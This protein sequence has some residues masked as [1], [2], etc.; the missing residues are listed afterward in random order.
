[1]CHHRSNAVMAFLLAE[2]VGGAHGEIRQRCR[3]SLLSG[4]FAGE[5]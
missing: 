4:Q 5:R 3:V 2:G 1:M